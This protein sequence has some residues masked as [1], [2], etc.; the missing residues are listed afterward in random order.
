MLTPDEFVAR[1]DSDVGPQSRIA[2]HNIRSW[3]RGHDLRITTLDP[4]ID[5]TGAKLEALRPEK[6]NQLIDLKP[7]DRIIKHKDLAP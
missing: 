3:K 5:L 2:E 1:L 6:Y 4:A 7:Y